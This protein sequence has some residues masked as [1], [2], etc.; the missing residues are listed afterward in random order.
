MRSFVKIIDIYCISIFLKHEILYNKMKDIPLILSEWDV[1]CK[2][3]KNMKTT[4][5]LF[6]LFEL[7]QLFSFLLSVGIEMELRGLFT[8][9]WL[10][11]QYKIRFGHGH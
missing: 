3:K 1:K 2:K 5:L 7:S 6:I 4:A 9:M 11:I 8:K 10:Y